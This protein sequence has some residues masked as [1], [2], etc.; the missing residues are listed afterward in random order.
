[1]IVINL[2]TIRQNRTE[3]HPARIEHHHFM[4]GRVADRDPLGSTGAPIG[5]MHQIA[6][7]GQI[8]NSAAALCTCYQRQL[9]I[10]S[11]IR[12][13]HAPYTPRRNV[14]ATFTHPRLEIEF[15][16]LDERIVL[17]AGW[18]GISVQCRKIERWLRQVWQASRGGLQL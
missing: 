16:R 14:T 17:R 1:E 15:T 6:T 9:T 12:R 2:A 11:D 7:L 3:L 10:R 5:H 8:E 13:E 18:G 4:T